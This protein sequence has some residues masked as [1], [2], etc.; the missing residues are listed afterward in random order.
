MLK[1]LGLSSITCGADR[2]QVGTE[3][4]VLSPCSQ[5]QD[6]V[7]DQEEKENKGTSAR[8]GESTFEISEVGIIFFFFFSHVSGW[9]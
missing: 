4:R 1:Y 6:P 8:W 3:N 9:P 5:S 7:A 2:A